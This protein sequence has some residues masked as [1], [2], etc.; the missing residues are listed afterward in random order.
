MLVS[1]L[2]AQ[3]FDLLLQLLDAFPQGDL[4]DLDLRDFL[5]QLLD[6]GLG[7]GLPLL[8][9]VQLLPLLVELLTAVPVL[10]P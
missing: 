4:V 1:K 3:D 10:V 5:L 9:L 8:A 2:G 7:E 6:L